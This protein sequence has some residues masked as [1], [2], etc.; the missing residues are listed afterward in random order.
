MNI[1]LNNPDFP[2]TSQYSYKDN[3]K[4]H[5]SDIISHYMY[6]YNSWV[7]NISIYINPLIFNMQNYKILKKH[8]NLFLY[9]KPFDLYPE[10]FINISNILYSIHILP[11][12]TL[13]ENN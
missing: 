1:L 8:N 9:F 13:Y 2:N 12:L 5:R 4:Y 10:Y 6:T 11:F 3:F 7:I